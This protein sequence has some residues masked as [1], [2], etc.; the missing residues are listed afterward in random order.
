MTERLNLSMMA[1]LFQSQQELN[2]RMQAS[3]HAGEHISTLGVQIGEGFWLVEMSDISEVMPLP[4]ITTV[5]LTKPWFCGVANVRGNLYSVVDLAAF[6]GQPKVLRD[7]Q[8]RVLLVAQKFALNSGLLVN[9]VIGLRDTHAWRRSE[10]DGMIQY[11]DKELH[12]WRQLDVAKL[13]EQPEFLHV[14]S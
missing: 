7:G 11:E 9:R 14:E 12:T 10:V 13:L 5:P 1:K 4:H 2:N 3:D 8:S 6:M